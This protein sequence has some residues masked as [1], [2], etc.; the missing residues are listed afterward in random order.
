[1]ISGYFGLL[2]VET[3]WGFWVLALSTLIFTV[4]YWH[5]F[6]RNNFRNIFFRVSLI[7]ISN[8]LVVSSVLISINKA[9]TFYASWSDF[10]GLQNNLKSEAISPENLASITKKD[11]RKAKHTK[12]GSLVFRKTITGLESGISARV[13]VVL[14][15]KIAKYLE[16]SN[17]SNLGT[18]YQ[19]IELFPGYPGVPET[20]LGALKGLNAIETLEK[21]NKIPPTIAII[22]SI[23]VVPGLDTECLNV[24]GTSEVETWLTRDIKTFAQKFI[25]IDD[26]KWSAFGYSTGGWC[27][28]S[29]GIRHQDQFNK[30]VSLAGYFSPTF[31]AGI[32]SNERKYLRTEYDL[33]NTLKS[34]TN[35]LQMLAIYSIQNDFE[36]RS[37]FDF[38]KKIGDLLSLKTI[39]IPYGGHNI[40]TWQ[41]YV[42]TGLEWIS[43][44]N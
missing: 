21:D 18:D 15:P 17:G 29:L 30:A 6:H 16:E 43:N 44:T 25:G 27:A 19:I 1:M 42:F 39:E 7:L 5:K 10:F 37:L 23:N 9:G 24:P 12:A 36:T 26:R 33:V 31:S 4:S 38:K 22:P 35:S 28:A 40:K 2:S 14:S 13:F 11:I 20:W 41:P 8:V 3:E 32:N 34:G